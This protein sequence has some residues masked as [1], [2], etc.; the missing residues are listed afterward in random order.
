MR[1]KVHGG[2]AAS[3]SGLGLCGSCKNAYIREG[4]NS[5][6]VLCTEARLGY[7]EIT[8]PIVRCRDYQDASQ[9]TKWN[10]EQIA[11]TISVDAKTK[12][13]GFKPPGE[14]EKK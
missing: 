7:H 12:K 10:L 8:E 4:R 14:P 2:T 11:W 13:V 6:L 1:V 5:V 9:P 3:G